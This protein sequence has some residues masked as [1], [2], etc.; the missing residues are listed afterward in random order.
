[1]G[2]IV[3]RLEVSEKAAERRAKELEEELATK[4]SRGSP[5][6]RLS[7]PAYDPLLNLYYPCMKQISCA[8]IGARKKRHY[9]TAKTPFQRLLEQPFEDVLEGIRV[10]SDLRS[11]DTLKLRDGMPIVQQRDLLAKAVDHLLCLAHDVPVIAPRRGAQ[12]HG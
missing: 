3:K 10:K 6:S 8:R 9:D 2:R 4:G 11:A 5:S 12:R 1:M 7:T